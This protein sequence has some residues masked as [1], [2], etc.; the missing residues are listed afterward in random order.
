MI[1]YKPELNPAIQGEASSDSENKTQYSS[2]KQDG[3]IQHYIRPL[4]IN[5]KK[6]DIRCYLFFNSNPCIALFHPGYLRLTIED[7]SEENIEEE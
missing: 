7:Y 1:H 2:L 5:K 4:L 6:F 3:L